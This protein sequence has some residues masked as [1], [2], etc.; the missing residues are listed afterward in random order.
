MCMSTSNTSVILYLTV[1]FFF[2]FI[3]DLSLYYLF[4]YR[5]LTV[6]STRKS[7]LQGQE[8]HLIHCYLYSERHL[9]YSRCSNNNHGMNKIFKTSQSVFGKGVGTQ[10]C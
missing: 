5:S 9:A 10:L 4:A 8:L 1:L 2:F 3:N 6:S 7:D